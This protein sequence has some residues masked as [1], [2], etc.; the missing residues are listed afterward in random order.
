MITSPLLLTVVEGNKVGV[1]EMTLACSWDQALNAHKKVAI[2]R[3]R[4]NGR[5]NSLG[6]LRI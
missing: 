5:I 4:K 3:H 2:V 1:L 6:V